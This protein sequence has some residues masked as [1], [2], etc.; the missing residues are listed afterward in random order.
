MRRSFVRRSESC[1]EVALSAS[2]RAATVIVQIRRGLWRQPD[3]FWVT[4]GDILLDAIVAPA[5]FGNRFTSHC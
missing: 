2:V 1:P 4:A 3:A 5:P